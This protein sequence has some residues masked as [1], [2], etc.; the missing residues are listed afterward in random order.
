MGRN[1][2]SLSSSKSTT[3]Q[4]RENASAFQWV[5][6]MFR[7]L[8]SKVLPHRD[9]RAHQYLVGQRPCS[10]ILDRWYHLTEARRQ[11]IISMVQACHSISSS[12][13][14]SMK[15]QGDTT[16]SQWFTTSSRY[17]H[18]MVAAWRV[19]KTQLYLSGQRLDFN[20]C[21]QR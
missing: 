10:F 6:I 9:Q 14:G 16:A 12:N 15:T 17:A 13:G 20:V 18:P 8:R 5:R 1:P 2:D 4:R 11:S 7:C 21:V 3:S 19:R